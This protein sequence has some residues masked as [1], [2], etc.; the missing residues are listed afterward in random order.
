MAKAP[1]CAKIPF[2]VDAKQRACAR[3]AA[4]EGCLGWT[5]RFPRYIEMLRS[6]PKSRMRSR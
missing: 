5:V 6:A 3:A 4:L 2:A 1:S